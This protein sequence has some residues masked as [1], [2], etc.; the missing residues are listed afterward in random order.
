MP[1]RQARARLVLRRRARQS[2]NLRLVR[3][4]HGPLRLHR[5]LRAGTP[6][7]GRATASGSDVLDLSVSSAS[8]SCA[9]RAA[10]SSP[11]TAGRTASGRPTD[12]RG[13][14]TSPGTRWRPTQF[15]INEFARWARKAGVEAMYALNL[16]TRGVQEALDLPRVPQPPSGHRTLR[17]AREPRRRNRTASACGAS[18]TR[19]T[20]PGRSGT[21]PLDEY[22]RLAA[23]MARAL[24]PA[25]A[26][27]RAR[28]LRELQPLD[29]NLRRLGGHRSRAGV[30]PGGLHLRARVLRGGRRRPRQLPSLGRQHGPLHRQR[31][32]H[33]GQRRS[34]S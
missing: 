12:A 29:A 11:A 9:T 5:D 26:Q 18:A 19:W 31:G 4:A 6:D 24:R 13:G 10:T 32:R 3:R 16:G 14:S 22:G 27:P 21:R 23:E 7:R 17:P 1:I 33:R 15:G 30:R 20:A 28:R 8:P 25:R 34:A 2:P